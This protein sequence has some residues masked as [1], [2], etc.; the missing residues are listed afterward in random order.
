MLISKKKLKNYI[1]QIKDENRAENIGQNYTEPI[2]DGQKAKNLYTQ[3]YEDGTDNL[4]NAICA[5][6]KLNRH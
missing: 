5:K 6:F 2:S 1:K 4:Y 3:G